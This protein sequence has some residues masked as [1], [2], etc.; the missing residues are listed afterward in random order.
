MSKSPS[1]TVR[2][3]LRTTAISVAAR[4][5]NQV[6][7]PAERVRVTA[8]PLCSGAGPDAWR[9]AVGGIAYAAGASAGAD[10]I[11]SL[12]AGIDRRRLHAIYHGGSVSADYCERLMPLIRNIERRKIGFRHRARTMFAGVASNDMPMG[13]SRRI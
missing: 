3:L 9:A 11:L 2:P 5:G 1:M 13:G 12:L 8:A 10:Y 6:F 4:F 7:D